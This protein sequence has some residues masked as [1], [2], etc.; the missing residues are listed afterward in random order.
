MADT[1]TEL[2]ELLI[3]IHDQP[4]ARDHGLE[5]LQAAGRD[6]HAAFIDAMFSEEG[7]HSLLE[8]VNKSPRP[9]KV[10]STRLVRWMESETAEPSKKK[11]SLDV[12][13]FYW[14]EPSRTARRPLR[15][16]ETG[17]AMEVYV[18]PGASKPEV[19]AGWF[20]EP[21]PCRLDES[22]GE[23]GIWSLKNN[24]LRGFFTA[25]WAVRPFT[26]YIEDDGAVSLA[27]F[28]LLSA[29]TQRV[30]Y[31]LQPGL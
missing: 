6:R 3:A 7:A 18:G 17:M 25:T 23:I 30:R 14:G 11:V 10:G 22:A 1:L 13:G 27:L 20:S 24:Q 31:E 12:G 15:F 28:N 19:V 8:M 4:P 16:F 5:A 29:T 2:R 26:G 9:T 21:A